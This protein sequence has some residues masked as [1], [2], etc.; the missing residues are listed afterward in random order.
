RVQDINDNPPVF[1]RERYV[2][3]VTEMAD[4]GTSIIQVTAHDADDPTY[5]NSARLVYTITHGQDSFS[6]DP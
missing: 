6:I 1:P 4:I 2:A 5:G 3:T